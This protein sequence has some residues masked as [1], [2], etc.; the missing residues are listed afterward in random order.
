MR[1][2]LLHPEA[3][4]Y[5]QEQNG[6]LVSISSEEEHDFL[7]ETFVVSG[8][9]GQCQQHYMSIYYLFFIERSGC[10][11]SDS[12]LVFWRNIEAVYLKGQQRFESHSFVVALKYLENSTRLKPIEIYE[13]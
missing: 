11:H 8:S 7:Y 5:C 2:Q 3:R 10:C 9:E 6:H 13:H 1:T 4:A 12:V